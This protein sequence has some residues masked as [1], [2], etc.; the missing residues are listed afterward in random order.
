LMGVKTFPVELINTQLT[1][2][3]LIHM[4]RT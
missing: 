4:K 2:Q 3:F 1:E